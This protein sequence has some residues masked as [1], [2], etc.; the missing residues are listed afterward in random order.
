MLS[1]RVVK[2]VDEDT[3]Y[4]LDS[5]KELHENTGVKNTGVRNTGVRI[6]GSE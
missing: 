3:I 1:G 2:V 5:A 6:P 4:V